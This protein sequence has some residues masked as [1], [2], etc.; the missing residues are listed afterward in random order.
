MDQNTLQKRSNGE[1]EPAFVPQSVAL[2]ANIMNVGMRK[3]STASKVASHKLFTAPHAAR[4]GQR[5][6]PQALAGRTSE[7]IRSGAV[8]AAQLLREA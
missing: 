5:Q 7:R 4:A 2:R 1:A 3:M 8:T 6:P